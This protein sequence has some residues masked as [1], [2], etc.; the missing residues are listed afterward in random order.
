MHW[1]LQ[2]SPQTTSLSPAGRHQYHQNL[3]WDFDNSTCQNPALSSLIFQRMWA[4]RWSTTLY[5]HMVIRM[6]SISLDHEPLSRLPRSPS[7]CRC[8]YMAVPRLHR[9]TLRIFSYRGCGSPRK[10]MA[11]SD[12]FH[13]YR[14]LNWT[15]REPH[16]TSR[17]HHSLLMVSPTIPRL[18]ARI[19]RVV[20]WREFLWTWTGW[21]D[22]WR[23]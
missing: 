22:H 7:R 15:L 11:N 12:R 1:R 14:V 19:W 6:R 20:K 18:C 5:W 10:T 21:G 17:C 8:G 23:R 4:N 13:V 3:S 9:F 16:S 2:M